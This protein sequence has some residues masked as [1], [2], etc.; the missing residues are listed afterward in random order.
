MAQVSPILTTNARYTGAGCLFLALFCLISACSSAPKTQD[1]AKKALSGTDEQ[2]FLGDSIKK[3]YDP[4]VIMKRGEAFFE[5]EEY[6][7]A[8]V[9]YTHFLDLHRAHILAPYAEFRIGESQMKLTKGIQRDPAPIQ[10]ALEAFERLRKTFPGSRYDGPALQKIQ[11]CHDLLAQTHLFVGEFYYRRG[12]Y[13]AAAH[14]FEQIMK[15]YPDKSVAPDALYFLAL[16]YHD[17]GADDWASEQLT[18]LAEKYP[19]SAYSGEGKSLLAKIGGKNPP[20]LLALKTESTSA[21]QS[22]ASPP[23]ENRPSL[24]AGLSPSAPATSFRLP[25]A[26]SLGQSFVSCRLGAWC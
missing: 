2:I 18:L 23:S 12:S 17:L 8:I 3:N 9:E 1:T 16:S 19:G 24:S 14:R 11:E 13:L 26:A 4:N 7:E 21:P 22:P 25:S 20:T 15:L 10:K 6:T 5:K